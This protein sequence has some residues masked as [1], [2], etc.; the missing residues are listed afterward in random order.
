MVAEKALL[1]MAERAVADPI[2]ADNIEIALS[3]LRIAA[4]WTAGVTVISGKRAV[5]IPELDQMD[6]DQERKDVFLELLDN[7]LSIGNDLDRIETTRRGTVVAHLSLGEAVA[8]DRN[9]VVGVRNSQKRLETID[10][11]ERGR[12]FMVDGSAVNDD[13]TEYE[14]YRQS[15]DRISGGDNRD[16][17]PAP[18]L[19]A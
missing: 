8:I 4:S 19:A 6:I 16:H 7:E 15:G 2:K 18:A 10:H 9:G 11:P 5:N 1:D 14:L 3:N 12:V 13:R 17:T